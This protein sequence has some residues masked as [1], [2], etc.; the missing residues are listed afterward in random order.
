MKKIIPVIFKHTVDMFR[1]TVSW[2]IK[3]LFNGNFEK[4]SAQLPVEL[5]IWSVVSQLSVRPHLIGWWFEGNKTRMHKAQ[6]RLQLKTWH[7]K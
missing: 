4:M 7:T 2:K 6:F 3:S 5:V 1:G